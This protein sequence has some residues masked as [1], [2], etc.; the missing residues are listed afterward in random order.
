[1]C[2]P[3]T[4]ALMAAGTA[5]SVGGGLVARNE[6]VKNNSR[7]AAARNQ[8]LRDMMTRQSQLE[9]GNRDA[10]NKT[11]TKF[12]QPA[13]DAALANATNTRTN[14]AVGNITPVSTATSEVPLA[15]NEPQVI[16]SAMASR[17]A[18]AFGKS[19]DLARARAKLGSYGDT[20]GANNREVGAAG[21]IVDTGNNFSRQ[22]AALLPARQ[23]LAGY[24]AS[25]PPSGIGET[26]QALGQLAGS[27]AGARGGG[28]AP[29]AGL[30]VSS[31]YSPLPFQASR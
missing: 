3:V 2:D 5:A 7:I 22:E 17:M 6:G 1:M 16:K 12:Q 11:L 13:Q 8:E 20:L 21:R 23:D 9:Q 24:I 27:A 4:A 31:F 19:T 10:V 25:K 18:D 15:G 14:D 30:D 26:I 29:R 28:G